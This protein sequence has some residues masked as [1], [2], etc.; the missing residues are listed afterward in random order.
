MDSEE[1]KAYLL[2][3]SVIFHYHGLDDEEKKNLEESTAELD[4]HEEMQ[5]VND[6]IAEDYFNSFDRARNYLND[7]I[8]NYPKD[9][10]VFYIDM[11]WKANNLKGYVTELEATAMLQ[12]ARDWH[13][14]EDLI[15]IL[16][17]SN[18]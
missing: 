18:A 12:L 15:N 5:W 3:K 8:G 17:S 16:R 10:R 13:V 4:G 14:E 11:V 7:I 6:F 9:K 2:L 1:K